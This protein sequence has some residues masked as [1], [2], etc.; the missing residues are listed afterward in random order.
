M[1][2]NLLIVA[3]AVVCFAILGFIVNFIFNKVFIPATDL[4]GELLTPYFNSKARLLL[5]EFFLLILLLLFITSII[6]NASHSLPKSG[7]KILPLAIL[8][9]TFSRI[10]SVIA[11]NVRELP[12]QKFS[13]ITSVNNKIIFQTA[14]FRN[15]VFFLEQ[16]LSIL[17]VIV[18]LFISLTLLAAL[19]WSENV[20]FIAFL[21]IPIYANYWIYVTISFKFQPAKVIVCRRSLMYA[22]L[23]VVTIWQAYRQFQLSI[24]D[25]TFSLAFED[26]FVYLSA[27]IFASLDKLLKE[28]IDRYL[29]KDNPNY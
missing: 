5:I 2:Q 7:D 10:G 17:F 1:L 27:A 13:I 8:F 16:A 23:L 22:L 18:A 12:P 20:Y 24:H 3:L 21:F 6:F 26:L 15:L 14:V 9:L 11:I 28:P 25:Q 19:E 4:L 29:K